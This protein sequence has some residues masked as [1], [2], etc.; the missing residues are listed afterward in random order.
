MIA[1]P[2]V[3]RSQWRPIKEEEAPIPTIAN[4]CGRILHYLG[5]GDDASSSC[6]MKAAAEQA[7]WAEFA[8]PDS[9]LV[10]V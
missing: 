9:D 10:L 2:L 3:C 5:H 8:T 7:R 1:A 6:I 4:T